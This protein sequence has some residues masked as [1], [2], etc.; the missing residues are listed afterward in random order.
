MTDIRGRSHR[1]GYLVDVSVDNDGRVLV[2]PSGNLRFYRTTTTGA[3]SFKTTSNATDAGRNVKVLR[4]EVTFDTAPTT[5]ENLTLTKNGQVGGNDPSAVL[6]SSNPA[7]DVSTSVVATWEG[8]YPLADRDEV[9]LAYTNTD[10]RTI[11][12]EIVLEVL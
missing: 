9:T 10:A 1:S 4:Y 8:G 3:L 12:A 5:S 6:S 2:T 11:K 7:L